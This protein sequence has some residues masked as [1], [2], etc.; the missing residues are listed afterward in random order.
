MESILSHCD[1]EIISYG[2]HEQISLISVSI[3]K[4]ARGEMMW[5]VE[6]PFFNDQYRIKW[7]ASLEKNN[8]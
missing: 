8:I 1:H 6:Y 7:I 4:I 3:L 5:F 2:I